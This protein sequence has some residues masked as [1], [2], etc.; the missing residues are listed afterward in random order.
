M[1]FTQ[2]DLKK[3]QERIAALR[4]E[5]G[6]LNNE[7]ERQKRATGYTKEAVAAIDLES[8]PP[9]MKAALVKAQEEARK[10]GAARAAQARDNGPS[11]PVKAPGAGRRNAIRL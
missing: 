4:E 7:L 8:M 10:A 9:A 2:E 5:F 11:K 1:K 3:Q 6:R